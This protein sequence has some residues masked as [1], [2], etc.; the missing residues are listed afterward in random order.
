M[1]VFIFLSLF[2]LAFAQDSSELTLYVVKSPLGMNWETP[3]KALASIQ[4]NRL[5]L[6]KHPLGSVFTEVKC[7][8]ETHLVSS[9]YESL[10]LFNQLVLNQ[11]GLGVFFHSFPGRLVKGHNLQDELASNIADGRVQFITFSLN[12][13]QCL[14]ALEYLKEYEEKNVAQNWGFSNIPRKGEGGT[15]AALSMSVLEILGF[16]EEIFKEGW[17]RSRKVPLDLIGRPREDRRVSFFKILGS[18]WA[19]NQEPYHLL[20]F[21]DP[22][23]M[24]EW[25]SRNLKNFPNTKKANIDGILL[26]R[27][28]FPT[29]RI[30]FWLPQENLEP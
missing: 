17:I 25:I 19:K 15:S 3:S 22:E 4:K 29:L 8:K 18:E 28:H 14:R 11:E 13:E 2:S 21:P 9:T 26:D 23:L 30:P 7:T 27:R 1:T 16:Q 6:T 5:I 10:D 12:E 24:H 20:S